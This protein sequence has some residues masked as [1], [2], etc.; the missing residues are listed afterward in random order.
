MPRTLRR[1]PRLLG[2][3]GPSKALLDAGALDVEALDVEAPDVE[4]RFDG[5]GNG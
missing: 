4:D 1:R 5:C 2:T 3:A